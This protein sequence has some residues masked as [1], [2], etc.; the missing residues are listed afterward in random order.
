MCVRT[1]IGMCNVIGRHL[2]SG[3]I[4]AAKKTAAL[5]LGFGTAIVVAYSGAVLAFGASITALFTEEAGV[6]AEREAIW[7]WA[8]LFLVL[9]AE[10]GMLA[11]LNRALGI[12]DWSAR[13]VWLCLWVVG[14]PLIFL[15]SSDL[16]ATWRL[17]PL[18]YLIFDVALLC[19]SA[20]NDW[21]RLAAKAKSSAFEA[22]GRLDASP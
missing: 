5:A 22:R 6:M 4:K 2:G 1:G 8:A 20:C 10:F 17:L 14:T 18:I 12:Q 21:S 19:C 16:R 3:D 9:D 15:G 13:C 7:P 11:G